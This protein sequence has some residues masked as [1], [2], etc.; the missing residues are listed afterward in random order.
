M[1]GGERVTAVDLSKGTKKRKRRWG[2]C[3]KKNGSHRMRAQVTTD[4]EVL[5]VW[6]K[7]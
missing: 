3:G 6:S 5:A 7:K 2:T 4:I 1:T